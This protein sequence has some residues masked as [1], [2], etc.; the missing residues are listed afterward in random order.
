[1]SYYIDKGDAE[2]ILTGAIDEYCSGNT[3]PL[4]AHTAMKVVRKALEWLPGEDVEE[5]VYC[6]DCKNCTV[7][8]E[9]GS[10][11]CFG[12]GGAFPVKPSGYCDL[13]EHKIN[14]CTTYCA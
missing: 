14:D 7:S 1:M 4:T 13:G 3:E 12:H 5:V 11:M 6:R 9:K 8:K 2:I 10:L